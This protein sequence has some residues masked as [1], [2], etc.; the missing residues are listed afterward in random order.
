LTLRNQRTYERRLSSGRPVIQAI[1]QSEY[2]NAAQAKSM[3][4]AQHPLIVDEH[5]KLLCQRHAPRP[6]A[7]PLAVHNDQ[8][9]TVVAELAE[10]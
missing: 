9:G 5:P 3:V 6:E 7:F 8:V 10:W 4:C 1:V 2:M